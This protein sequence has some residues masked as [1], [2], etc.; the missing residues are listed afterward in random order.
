LLAEVCEKWSVKLSMGGSI[1]LVSFSVCLALLIYFK[2]TK[3]Y[4]F[5]TTLFTK[6]T[7]KICYSLALDVFFLASDFSPKTT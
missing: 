1:N 3:T 4:A 5:T 6:T 7:T 2:K